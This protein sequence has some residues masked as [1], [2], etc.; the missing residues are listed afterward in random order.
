MLFRS[1]NNNV[2]LG[3]EKVALSVGKY[4]LYKRLLEPKGVDYREYVSKKLLPDEALYNLHNN[5]IYIIEKK[6]Q[7]GA[8][9]VDEK[10]QTCD[11]KK[12]QYKKL[13]TPIDIEVQYFYVCNDFF[14]HDSYRDVFDYIRSVGCNAFFNEIPLDFLCL[15]KVEEPAYGR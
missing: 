6:F 3:N 7:S 8:G 10:L 12:K 9:S 2:Y 15:P 1:S 5:T 11:F 13:F 4:D 14:K